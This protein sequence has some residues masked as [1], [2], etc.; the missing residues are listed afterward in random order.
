MAT[1]AFLFDHFPGHIIPSFTLANDLI[2]QGHKVCYLAIPDMVPLITRQGFDC[3]VV[4]Q[5]YFPEGFVHDAEAA[6]GYHYAG[7]IEGCLDS[8]M[9]EL[10]PDLMVCTYFVSLD[11]L[12]I[13][14]KYGIPQV[15]FT[16]HIRDVALDPAY[17]AQSIVMKLHAGMAARVLS[18][19]QQ[20]NP[21]AESTSALLE[22]L[23]G[24]RE[25]IAAP[26][27]LLLPDEVFPDNVKFITTGFNQRVQGEVPELARL[28][29]EGK[30]IIFASM[31]SQS[32]MHQDK[33]RY[34]F[35]RMLQMMRHEAPSHWHMVLAHSNMDIAPLGKLPDN[36]TAT[37]WIDQVQVLSYSSLAVFHGGIGTIKE[38]LA[39]EV[40]MVICPRSI[41]TSINVQRVES[42]EIGRGADL[43]RLTSAE[44][45]S[46]C[47]EVMQDKTLQQS[48]AVLSD[49]YVKEED[50]MKGASLVLPML[51]T[52]SI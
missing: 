42:C 20:G 17:F 22:P 32:A 49:R 25:L 16:T 10:A 34:F 28:K 3:Q 1:I 29:E 11:S 7:I 4:M 43:L 50:E 45:V 2:R 8:V 37:P 51:E 26:R 9:D 52:M 24:F 23:K 21:S 14:Q 18:F 27:D 41:E 48:I 30:V 33:T 46:L 39:A 36:V 13:N 31:G 6:N 44:L 5:E 47:N 19:L 15:L 35:H 12:L 38:C 40:P